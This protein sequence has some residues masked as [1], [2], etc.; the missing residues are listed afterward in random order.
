MEYLFP[1]V[2]TLLIETP[3]YFEL[4]KEKTILNLS[5]IILMNVFTNLTFNFIYVRLNYS[6]YWL[7]FGEIIIFLLEGLILYF[8][9][10]NKYEFLISLGGN[11]FSLVSGILF[12]LYL[13]SYNIF[14]ILCLVFLIIFLI[15]FIF[16]II[17]LSLKNNKKPLKLK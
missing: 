2:L 10:K 1:L 13:N 15:Y 3:I 11:I 4:N 12:N 8:I 5:Y 16:R 9:Y 7:I 17:Y 14:I 6:L